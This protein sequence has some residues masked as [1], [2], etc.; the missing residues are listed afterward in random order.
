MEASSKLT[1]L[2]LIAGIGPFPGINTLS[3]SSIMGIVNHVTAARARHINTMINTGMPSSNIVVATAKT[4]GSSIPAQRK[5]TRPSGSGFRMN[6]SI[7]DSSDDEKHVS[8]DGDA[9]VE[10]NAQIDG[11][12]RIHRQ[13]RSFIKLVDKWMA[14]TG[15]Y[16]TSGLDTAMAFG[17]TLNP[18]T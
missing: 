6:G 10:D 17:L 8:S 15:F 11:S 7:D 1:S 18:A 13:D 5:T 3:G 14:F 12:V 16:G 4:P 2:Q 9:D